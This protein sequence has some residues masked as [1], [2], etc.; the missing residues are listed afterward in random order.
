MS[1]CLVENIKK[2]SKN[3]KKPIDKN[4]TLVYN[5]VT[6]KE[7][8]TSEGSPLAETIQA[9]SRQPPQAGAKTVERG[10][11]RIRQSNFNDEIPGFVR[12]LY[13]G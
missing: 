3:C 13:G 12:R 10:L 7:C 11:S 9:G 5:E 1:K 8:I 4:E 2:F 6:T